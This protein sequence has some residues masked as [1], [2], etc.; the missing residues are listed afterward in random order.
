MKRSKFNL[1]HYKLFSG[2]MGYLMPVACVEV[3]PGDT[4]QHATSMLVRASPLSTPPMHPV[5][6]KVHHWYVPFRLIWEDFEDFI[7]GG[8]DGLDASVMPY[9][10]F[11][12]GAVADGDLADYLGYPTGF[13]GNAC[14]LPF[15]AY[16]KIFNECYRDQDLITALGLAITSGADAT[17]ATALQRVSWEKDRFTSARPWE[18]KGDAVSLPLGTTAPVQAN[19][20]LYVTNAGGTGFLNAGASNNIGYGGTLNAAAV[21]YYSG[22]EVD[23][24]GATSVDVNLVKTAFALQKYKE[25]RARY[26]SRYTEY[27][28]YLGVRSSDARLS[29]PE[30]LG[31]GV[32]TLQFSEILQTGPDSGD[33]GVGSLKGHGIGSLRSNRY[34]KYFE[35]HG[36]VMSL[37]YVQ[38]RTMYCQGVPRQYLRETKEDFWQ[39]E[40]QHIGQHAI[41]NKEIYFADSAPNDVFGYQDPYDEYRRC[42]SSVSGEFRSSPLYEWHFARLFGSD[43]TLNADFI[44]SNPSKRA[45]QDQASHVLWFMAYHQMVARRQI[46]LR[47]GGL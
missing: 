43:V 10:D 21:A 9:I 29:R 36:Y 14:A 13:N 2:D 28:A 4:I 34:R 42:E 30:Y 5:K 32:E 26:G 33:A 3:L 8:P 35:E 17:T 39:R 46:A 16:A 15:R 20:D 19:G 22:L 45:F 25:A 6:M 1:S 47:G 7:T 27:L 38:P 31:G 41:T 44:S 11:S 12:G 40:L 23:L 37:V 18:Q 24:S